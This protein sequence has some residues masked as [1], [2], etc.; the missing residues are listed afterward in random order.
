MVWVDVSDGGVGVGWMLVHVGLVVWV[1]VH[2]VC[3]VFL[4]IGEGCLCG[5]VL[6]VVLVDGCFVDGGGCCGG[7]VVFVQE[8]VGVVVGM[9]GSV[10]A[11]VVV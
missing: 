7:G 4:G 2:V 6:L 3:V 5:C 10:V 8:R 11:L 9:V 1:D